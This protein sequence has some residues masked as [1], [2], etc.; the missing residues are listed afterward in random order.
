VEA[1]R[2]GG[3]KETEELENET[4]FVW[5][6]NAHA[7]MRKAV[8]RRQREQGRTGLKVGAIVVAA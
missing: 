6:S 8:V 2:N 1:A 7:A 5:R 3:S 4:K